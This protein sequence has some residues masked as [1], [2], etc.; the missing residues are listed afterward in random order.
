MD[1]SMEERIDK[2]LTGQRT[3]LWGR[4]FDLDESHGQSQAREFILDLLIDLGVTYEDVEGE[5]GS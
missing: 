4:Y 5:C 3:V 2:Y 1:G